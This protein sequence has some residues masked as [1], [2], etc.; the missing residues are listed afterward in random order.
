MNN[1]CKTSAMFLVCRLP[2][3]M[4]G[5]LLLCMGFVTNAQANITINTSGA[6]IGF[7]RPP[8]VAAQALELLLASQHVR[9]KAYGKP[10]LFLPPDDP[11]FVAF[12]ER[13]KKLPYTDARI[14]VL[15]SADA[16]RLGV[17]DIEM[18]A[19]KIVRTADS[20]DVVKVKLIQLDAG[21]TTAFVPIR[22]LASSKNKFSFFRSLCDSCWLR[23]FYPAYNYDRPIQIGYRAN[24]SYR[25]SF[26]TSAELRKATG[27][28][29]SEDLERVY[30]NTQ[31]IVLTVRG[32]FVLVVATTGWLLLRRFRHRRHLM[33][34]SSEID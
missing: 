4:I 3:K 13:L 24:D 17:N 18:V 22:C 20:S 27:T 14:A 32:L 6:E 10:P 7:R 29:T 12:A 5:M 16:D 2:A 8:I 25:I 21:E 34:S 1:L 26:L 23:P 31:P 30:S 15:E 11:D 33:N 28:L 19:A 9:I